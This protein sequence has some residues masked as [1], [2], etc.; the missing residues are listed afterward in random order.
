MKIRICLADDHEVV[1][2]GFR[3]LLEKQPDCE[4]IGE[5]TDGQQIIKMARELNPDVVVMDVSLP[6]LNGIEATRQIKAQNPS[7]KILA[8]SVHTR[9]SVAG[10]V[11]K[12][13]ATAY[14]PKSSTVKELM[15]AIHAVMKNQ[16]YISPQILDTIVKY[17]QEESV[18]KGV[19][20][21][22]LTPRER[23]VLTLIVEGKTTKEISASLFVSEKTVTSHRYQIMQKLEIHNIGDLI[24]YAMREGLTSLDEQ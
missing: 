5:A 17:F 9:G 11:I 12:A 16:T 23:E 15:E 13:G 1:R 19:A 24:K 21:D 3:A 14:L 20:S 7:I 8:L 2:K 10:Q 4:V 18:H 6:N 22:R